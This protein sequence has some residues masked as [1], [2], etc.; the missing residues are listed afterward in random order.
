MDKGTVKVKADW[1]SLENYT[2]NGSSSSESLRNFITSF[3]GFVN[4][5]NT[6]NIVLDTMA[7]RGNDSMLRVAQADME[8]QK[9]K[10]TRFIEQYADTTASAPNAVFAAQVLNPAVE[11]DYLTAFTGGLGK[12]F[13]HSKLAK[14]FTAKFN[15]AMGQ[16]QPQEEVA[17]GPAIGTMAPDVTLTSADGKEVSIS[18]FKGKY[19][20]VDFWASWCGPCRRENPNVVKAYNNFKGK[21]F[22]ILGI[23]LDD[24]RSKW[25][26]AIEKDQLTW[27]HISD[28][29]GWE[30]MAARTYGVQSI[31]ANF[32]LGPDG[33]IIARD[34]RAEELQ[35]KLEEVLK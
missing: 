11:K 35:A 14:D 30:S 9:V 13:P 7:A 33:K 32:L 4:D 8:G 3:R 15:Q 12:R 18:S 5:M 24:D 28:L 20:L 23:S 31:P 29:K 34:L 17:A 2:V 25:L 10:L 19:V 6:M 27:T 16:T 21:N 22:T 1:N 26:A